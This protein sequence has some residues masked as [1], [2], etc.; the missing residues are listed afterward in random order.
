M[1]LRPSDLVMLLQ[2][3]KEASPE[4]KKKNRLASWLTINKMIVLLAI[5]GWFFLKILVPISNE[6]LMKPLFSEAPNGSWN[7]GVPTPYQEFHTGVD[8]MRPIGTS[9]TAAGSGIVVWADWWQGHGQTVWIFHQIN[10]EEF[11]TVYAHLNEFKVQRGQLVRLGQEIGTVGE[12]GVGSGPHLHFAVTGIGPNNAH[13]WGD[14]KNPLEFVKKFQGKTSQFGGQVKIA[15]YV[16]LLVAA[17]LI[18]NKFL[19]KVVAGLM[20]DYIGKIFRSCFLPGIILAVVIFGLEAASTWSSHSPIKS[21]CEVSAS[22]PNSIKKWCVEITTTAKKYG[23]DPD[24][25]AAQMLI[26][27]GGDANA[28][29]FQGAVGLMQ[30]MARDGIAEQFVNSEGVPLFANRPT[31]AQLKDPAF[32]LDYGVRLLAGLSK[33]TGSTREAIKAYGPAGVDYDYA[34][35]VLRLYEQYRSEKEKKK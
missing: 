18:L 28:V 13:Q 23:I 21:V 26:E 19:G 20:G 35:A 22:Y 10:G 34:D 16:C 32:N 27:S 5:A 14:W 24:L 15:G 29:S 2:K 4:K 7:F 17:L 3:N 6:S 25:I 33:S 12:T 11:Y 30:V 9:V 31:V 1:G 8:Y